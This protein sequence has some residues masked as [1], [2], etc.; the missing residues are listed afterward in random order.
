MNPAGLLQPGAALLLNA[1]FAWLAGSL[2]ARRWLG[3]AH[4]EL[5]AGLRVGETGAAA[6]C[7]GGSFVALW[8]ATAL[9][10]DVGLGEALGMLPMVLLQTG[11]GQAGL[12]GMVA[13]FLLLLAP[14]RYWQARA[15][16]LLLFA[17]ARAS[18][19]HAG[20]HGL[21][22]VAVGVEWL[23]L[24]LIGIWLGGV[25][26]AGW[27]V[28]RPPPA[29]LASLSGAATL[30]L[31]G[32]VATGLFNVL[33]RIAAPEQMLGHPYGIALTLKLVFV[34][35]A[36]GLGAYNRFIG[37]PQAARGQPAKALRVLRIES[38]VLLAA[39]AAAA[40]LVSTQPPA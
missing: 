5:E 12:A 33:Q 4:P 23:H 39:L 15:I 21:A 2:L 3:G 17:L 7:L 26:V 37:F 8:A 9:M 29:Y 18:V 13:A 30:A 28:A 10:G 31:A 36:V 27:L 19:S 35:C 25:G 34:A 24:V 1:G 20:E 32:I 38:L 22:S 40:V 6:A 14:H 16:L 11:Y